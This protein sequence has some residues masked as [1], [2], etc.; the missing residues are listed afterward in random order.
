[1]GAAIVLGTLR[2]VVGMSEWIEM[3]ASLGALVLICLA[4]TQ[5]GQMK[6]G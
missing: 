5:R 1:L 6:P 2:Y 3:V 4:F